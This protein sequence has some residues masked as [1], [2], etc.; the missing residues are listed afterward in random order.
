V[1]RSQD[2]DHVN[3]LCDPFHGPLICIQVGFRH[4]QPEITGIKRIA[5][6]QF[7]LRSVQKANSIRRVPGSR[8]Y[9]KLSAAQINDLAVGNDP[10]DPEKA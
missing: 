10:S 5:G 9:L 1:G 2:V 6:K 3:Q 8:D 7:P 4:P